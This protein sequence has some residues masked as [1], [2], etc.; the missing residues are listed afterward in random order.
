[1]ERRRQSRGVAL[2]LV[3]TGLAILSAFST[4]FSYRT[5]VDIKIATNMEKQV[6]AYF[7]ARSAMEIARLVITSQKFVNQA[8]SAFGGSMPGMNVKNFELWRYACKFAE[9]FSSSSLNFMGLELMNL[10]GQDGIGV[11]KGGFGCEVLPEDSRININA[12]TT[13]ADKRTLFTKLYALLRGAVDEDYRGGDDREAAELILNIMDW[14]D[15]DDERSDI[16]SNGNL[17]QAGGAGENVDYAKHGYQARN[18][19]MDSVE[20]VR[21]VEGMTDE[22]YCRFGKEFTVYNTGKLNVNEAELQLLKAILCDNL[23]EMDPYPI[24]WIGQVGQPPP[25]DLALG[26][27][28]MCRRIKQ[29]LF[30]PAFSSGND[31]IAFFDRL[32]EPLNQFIRLNAA[33]LR[34]MIGTQTKVLRVAARGW[35]G[36]SGHEITAVVDTSSMNYLYWKETGFDAAGKQN[37]EEKAM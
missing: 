9:I 28:Q 6:Q 14:T 3:L 32:P 31:F 8:V 37:T 2:V 7:H 34:P 17:V 27:M 5:R 26:M 1:M 29:A 21:L 16:D 11:A 13:V 30:T 15:P 35:V 36:E 33:T 4:E 23:V 18:A 22:L 25:M 10:K 12:A 20:E 24:C 19:K